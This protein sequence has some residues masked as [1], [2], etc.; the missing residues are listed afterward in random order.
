MPRSLIG[1]RATAFV[2]DASIADE[3]DAASFTYGKTAYTRHGSSFPDDDMSVEGVSSLVAGRR[4]RYQPVRAVKSLV[5]LRVLGP[6]DFFGVGEHL[7]ESRAITVK[8]V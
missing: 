3:S 8:K 5:Q 6:G 7:T 4:K 2:D 1:R